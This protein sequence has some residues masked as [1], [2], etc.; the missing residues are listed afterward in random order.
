MDRLKNRAAKK[1]G[2]RPSEI[3]VAS[4]VTLLR[5]L[6][7]FFFPHQA[8]DSEREEVLDFIWAAIGKE[9][10]LRGLYI[11][12][13]GELS[14]ASFDSHFWDLGLN[15][16]DG[17]RATILSHDEPNLAIAINYDDHLKIQGFAEGLQIDEAF[18]VADQADDLL[19]DNLPYA[20]SAEFGYLTE[21]VANLGAGI[22]VSL[23]L[24]LPAL[25]MN[26]EMDSLALNLY[27]SKMILLDGVFASGGEVFGN[28]YYLHKTATFGQSEAEVMAEVKTAAEMM[29]EKEM[30]ARKALLKE[31]KTRL[32]DE[33][34]R[35]FATLTH[36]KLLSFEEAVDNLSI[37]LLG[38]DLKLL[39]K[40]TPGQILELIS[41]ISPEAIV[42]LTVDDDDAQD[43][44]RAEMIKKRLFEIKE[45]G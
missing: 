44:L 23:V 41:S 37:L 26:D 38:A 21:S 22:K 43:G 20:F 29:V 4:Q 40:F 32:I 24:H 17:G 31:E 27:E 7:F 11:T 28:F 14:P 1:G 8:S 30:A 35:S 25:I 3:V 10:G 9:K 5:N 36:A 45:S 16:T 34:L 13:E 18:R 2:G 15:L 19:S 42:G 6:E 12:S 39:S 33:V